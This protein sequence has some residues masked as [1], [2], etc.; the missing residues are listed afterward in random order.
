MRL[1]RPMVDLLVLALIIFPTVYPPC[2]FFFKFVG[3]FALFHGPRCGIEVLSSVLE[4]KK[5]VVS[6]L[7]QVCVLD[8]L[9]LGI[10][11]SSFGCEFSI[12]RLAI[13]S[14]VK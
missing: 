1:N 11:Y 4:Y 5:A 14:F 12:S 3:D 9:C 7:D 13:L 10:S 8:K 2:F 6:L